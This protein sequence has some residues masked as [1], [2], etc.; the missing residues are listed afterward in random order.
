MTLPLSPEMVVVF[1]LVFARVGTTVCPDCDEVVDAGGVLA[2][3]DRI[4]SEWAGER[5]QIVAPLRTGQ[6]RAA[7]VRDALVKEGFS[8]LLSD[9]GSVVDLLEQAPRQKPAR[10]R[11][12][13]VLIDR[14]DLG[15]GEGVR[16]RLVEAV[17]QALAMASS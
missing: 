11:P 15:G 8:R 17:A 14:L 2:T 13:W 16:A 9:E 4:A 7:L 10:E 5:I 1:L 12:W 3:A 6:G